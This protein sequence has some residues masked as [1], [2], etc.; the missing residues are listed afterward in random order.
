M[1]KRWM[2][3]EEAIP[4]CAY[5]VT[6]CP[7]VATSCL[8]FV[9]C[10]R[11][12]CCLQPCMTMVWP[13]VL[14]K[15]VVNVFVFLNNLPWFPVEWM[16]FNRF[17]IW[18]GAAG[19][20]WNTPDVELLNNKFSDSL[21]I[22]CDDACV[23]TCGVMNNKCSSERTSNWQQKARRV[24]E[25]ESKLTNWKC[26]K[27]ECSLFTWICLQFSV[28]SWPIRFTVPAHKLIQIG[29]YGH[30]IFTVH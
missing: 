30:Q 19:K 5:V 8:P 16:G 3:S 25:E 13:V 28:K 22:K 26:W 21:V 2:Y 29:D 18:A 15:H 12:P 4:Q 24:A 10:H 14:I 6:Q 23:T 11:G 1:R 7:Y 20:Y 17:Q 27:Q 9:F